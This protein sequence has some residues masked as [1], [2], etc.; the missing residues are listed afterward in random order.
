MSQL[1]T[2]S[3]GWRKDYP[4]FRDFTPLT[5]HIPEESKKR[6]VSKSVSQ[7]LLKIGLLSS[8]A[9]KVSSKPLPAKADLR[10]W[11]SPIED[12]GDIGSC[13]AHVVVGLLEYFERR[14]FGIHID[15]SRLFLYKATRNLLHWTADDGAYLR[16]AIGAL[17][18]FGVPP[19]EYW[20]YDEHKFNHEPTPFCY[21]FAQNYKAISYYRLD[22]PN[23][24]PNELLNNIRT[25][26]SKGFPLVFG[27]TVY[28][29]MDEADE[30]G[31]KIPFPHP[32]DKVDGGHAVMAVGYDDKIK[33]KGKND[34]SRETTGAVLI[35]NSWG[36]DWGGLDGYLWLPYEYILKGLADDWWTLIK[37]EWVDTG[38]FGE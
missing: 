18:L 4:D 25:H 5:S 35:R 30:N 36:K 23:A 7:M 12:Q 32:K 14:A 17:A 28:K 13:T 15:A 6:G 2:K 33:I 22:P 9:K 29:S 24:D 26:L 38:A 27:F 16:S 3:M 31:G 10:K 21:S 19:E 20:P 1:R 34:G 11:C 37:N 8:S